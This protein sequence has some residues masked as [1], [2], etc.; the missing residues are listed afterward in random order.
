MFDD[1][2]DEIVKAARKKREAERNRIVP[3]AAEYMRQLEL[4][5]EPAEE[6]PLDRHETIR[7][8]KTLEAVTT[9]PKYGRRF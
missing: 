9:L 5:R 6:T 3:R 1:E 4:S 2:E 7:R 8:A